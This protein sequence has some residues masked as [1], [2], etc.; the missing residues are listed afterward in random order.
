MKTSCKD[1]LAAR[2][3]G[4]RWEWKFGYQAEKTTTAVVSLCCWS[5]AG[6][7]WMPTL[8]SRDSS[9][10]RE[11]PTAKIRVRCS[12]FPRSFAARLRELLLW[13]TWKRQ[14]YRIKTTGK[15]R[16][17]HLAAPERAGD[18][19]GTTSG[20]LCTHPSPHIPGTFLIIT[21]NGI[22]QGLS[23]IRFPSTSAQSCVWRQQSSH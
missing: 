6:W 4:K 20:R 19:A 14:P 1:S 18:H 9:K 10:S 23:G 21:V 5:A 22:P 12:P 3:P 15:K 13:S 8:E 16:Q 11:H 17:C 2:E 7:C